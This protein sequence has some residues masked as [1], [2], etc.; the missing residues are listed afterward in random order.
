MSGYFVC[1]E[2]LF[3]AQQDSSVIELSPESI[4]QRLQK[5]PMYLFDTL[6]DAK[7]FTR[8]LLKASVSYLSYLGR[9]PTQDMPIFEINT[10]R[11]PMDYSQNTLD[12]TTTL[13]FVQLSNPISYKI[14]NNAMLAYED[15]L[16]IHSIQ[17][18]TFHW[19]ES[20]SI[21]GMCTSQ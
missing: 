4:L 2:F 1:K 16:A 7:F 21:C 9:G 11:L 17:G 20:T 3:T 8:T 6:D 19:Q 14:F 5:L 18:N 12:I 13:T 10:A 15:I